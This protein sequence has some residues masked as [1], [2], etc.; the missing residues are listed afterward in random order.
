MLVD[1]GEVGEMWIWDLNGT[2]GYSCYG[3]ASE[4]DMLREDKFV[5]LKRR[6]TTQGFFSL[7]NDLE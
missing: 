7:K 1:E 2:V 5:A 6:S 4:I 3:L